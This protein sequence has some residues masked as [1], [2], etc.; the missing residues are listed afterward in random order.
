MESMAGTQQRVASLRIAITPSRADHPVPATFGVPFPKGGPEEPHLELQTKDGAPLPTQFEVADRWPDGSPRWILV[1]A[2]LPAEAHTGDELRAVLSDA[3]RA[4]VSLDAGHERLRLVERDETV[5]IDSGVARFRFARGASFPFA[6]VDCGGRR[7]LDPETSRLTVEDGAGRQA[8]G[9]I[10][11]VRVEARGPIRACIRLEGSF[12]I[13]FESQ[14]DSDGPPPSLDFIARVHAFAGRSSV[15]LHLTIRNPQPAHHPG[16]HWELGDA[17]SVLIRALAL[18]LGAPA[19]RTVAWSAEPS[20]PVAEKNLQHLEIVQDSSGGEHWNSRLHLDRDR[21][22]SVTFRGYREKVGGQVR[23]GLRASPWVALHD[24]S[25]GAAVH[26]RWFWQNFP[27]SIGAKPESLVLHFFPKTGAS[28]HE[29]QGGEQKTHELTIALGA[30]ALSPARGLDATPPLVHASPQWLASTAVIPYLEPRR[31]GSPSLHDRLVDQALEGPDTFEMKRERVDEYGWRHF[32]ELW[33]DHEAK[34]HEEAGEFAS[35]YNNQYDV[36]YGA[37]LQFARTGDPR[38]WSIHEELARH[39]I[40]VDIYHTNED[41][42]SYNQGLFWHTV[43]YVDADLST[44]RSYPKR[45]SPGGG[46][47]DEHN[48][49]TGLLHRYLTT[50]D[51]L[52]RETVLASAQWVIDADDGART[53][54]R[55][56]DPGRTGLATKTRAFD[57]HGPGRGAGNSLNALLDGWRLSGEERFRTKAIE[58]LRRV[59]HPADDLARRNL[60]DAENKWSYTVF[61]QALGKFL[62]VSADAGR[63]DEDYAYAR[64]ALLAYARWMAEHER[65]ILD[66]PERLEY[67][68]ETWA[69]QDVRKSDVFLFAAMHSEGMERARFLERQRYFFRHSLETLDKF[70]T[71]SFVRPVILLMH[72]GM[73]H[74]WFETNAGASRPEGPEVTSFGRSASFVPQKLRAIAKLK[75]LMLAGAVAAAL[76]ALLIG[77]Q[78]LR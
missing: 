21:N 8:R 35:H 27:K 11:S 59:I 4:G 9:V 3:S 72:Y 34:F 13:P 51:A 71:K 56:L 36:V 62:D 28:L 44:H 24:G 7:A 68:N 16:G 5:E 46:P 76:A 47:D 32:G 43:H 70:P 18:E 75:K 37:F 63:L 2:L 22:L 67:P 10:R 20:I 50:G 77:R 41:K 1:D 48:Y 39:V 66:T 73:M 60:L 58:V 78:L 57:Y 26:P 38:W 17:G 29:I 52:A 33:A 31:P 55:W 40:D 15:R 42:P 12:E 53:I 64:A 25:F 30:E 45:G 61:L 69:A 6:G 65:P 23:E 14:E 74:E 54:F 49:T 19:C